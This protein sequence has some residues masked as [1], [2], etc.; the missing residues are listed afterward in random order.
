MAT[1]VII[2]HIYVEL[3]E[4]HRQY[5]R[6]LCQCRDNLACVISS[7][8]KGWDSTGAEGNGKPLLKRVTTSFSENTT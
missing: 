8:P 5:T 1:A 6:L 4:F 2:M 3:C 7:I